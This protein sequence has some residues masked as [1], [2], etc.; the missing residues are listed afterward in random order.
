ME[1]LVLRASSEIEGSASVFCDKIASGDN[2]SRVLWARIFTSWLICRIKLLVISICYKFNL[3][4]MSNFAGLVLYSNDNNYLT[5]R[6]FN[7]LTNSVI[8]GDWIKMQRPLQDIRIVDR[9]P[10]VGRG[11]ERNC[12]NAQ[13][14]QVGINDY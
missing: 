1:N 2:Q 8:E 14:H 12:W 9:L 4:R 5:N 6:P 7:H 13:I 3:F 10:R 11:N